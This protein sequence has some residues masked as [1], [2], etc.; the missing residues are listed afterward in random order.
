MQGYKEIAK[1]LGVPQTQLQQKMLKL[2]DEHPPK[3]K[4]DQVKNCG[5]YVKH[6]FKNETAR[7]IIEHFQL[8]PIGGPGRP[9]KEKTDGTEKAKGSSRKRNSNA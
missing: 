1:A 9:K 3:F 8:N 5:H 4:P 7:E 2:Q 6:L